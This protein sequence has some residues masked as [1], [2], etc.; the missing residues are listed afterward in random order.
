[1][2]AAAVGLVS[3]GLYL[4]T[5]APGL[6]WAHDSADGGELAA[7]A[8]TLGIP[9]PPGYPTYVLLAHPLTRL[10]IGELAART[11]AF[12]ALCAAGAV[13]LL[14][15][16]VA[17][18]TGDDAAAAGAGL[19][20]GL[21]PL[22]W[23]QA[24]VTEVHALNAVFA[25]LLL[26]VAVRTESDWGPDAPGQVWSA[27][28]LG[29]AW[30]LGLGNHVTLIFLAPVVVLALWR[31]SGGAVYGLAGLV[32]GLLVYA[33]LPLRAAA[34]PAIA[35]GDPQTPGRFW[36]VVSGGPYRRFALSLPWAYV[37]QRL[38][39]WADLLA[40]QLGWIGLP[41]AAVGVGALWSE[42]RWL[43]VA[44]AVAVVLCSVFAVG[45]D[46]TDSYLHLIPALV[47]LALWLGKGAHWLIW[48][49][50][51]HSPS[52]SALAR[53]LVILLPAVAGLLRV[54]AMNL[55]QERIDRAFES[56]VVAPAP[57]RAVMVS[58]DDASTFALWYFQH[59]LGRRSDLVVADPGL[60]RYSWY[61]GQISR[62]IGMP[63]PEEVCRVN[64]E[65]AQAEA[66]AMLGRPV[67]A[68]SRSPQLGISCV[69]TQ[70]LGPAP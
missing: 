70:V 45:Y 52:V 39:A 46:T 32:A 3:L 17:L 41:V 43:L 69:G 63:V 9:H 20:L 40:R 15:W 68:V 23:S 62:Q 37:P 47:C 21:S 67:C 48:A 58:S 27:L 30:G 10:P 42:E 31:W 66:S 22:L 13:A 56:L 29:L 6:T 50:Q 5:L 12:S 4:A 61:L 55:G 60:T 7:S 36:W 14:T 51:A 38:W 8:R 34:A 26:A 49:V 25:A 53:L 24:I 11:N 28:A 33:Y 59:G 54:P 2:V 16:T 57:A 35:W 18:L 64:D 1:L 19:A 44:T 65:V